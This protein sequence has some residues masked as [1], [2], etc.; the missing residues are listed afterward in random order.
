MRSFV[1]QISDDRSPAAA[2]RKPR[3]RD[4]FE[5]KALAKRML[6]ETYHHKSVQVWEGAREICHLNAQER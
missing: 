5:A 4:E 1:F 2:V 3:V 6:R